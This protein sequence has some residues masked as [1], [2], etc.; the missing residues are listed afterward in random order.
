LWQRFLCSFPIKEKEP[1]EGEF[2][3][4]LKTTTAFE[5]YY[6]AGYSTACCDYALLIFYF[7]D[8]PLFTKKR[9]KTPSKFTWLFWVFSSKLEL[10]GYRFGRKG[11]PNSHGFFL[12]FCIKKG[13]FVKSHPYNIKQLN[14]FTSEQ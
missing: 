14:E 13:G 5:L 4:A 8:T 10:K 12:S 6:Q 9:I 2:R 3:T 1:L 11:A 7:K